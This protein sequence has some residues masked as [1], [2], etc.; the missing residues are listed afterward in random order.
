MCGRKKCK[1][2][3]QST[4]RIKSVKLFNPFKFYFG[5]R[6]EGKLAGGDLSPRIRWL[7][8]G[9]SNHNSRDLLIRTWIALLFFIRVRSANWLRHFILFYIIIIGIKN[10]RNRVFPTVESNN[11]YLLLYF[12]LYISN[13]L[14]IP[15]SIGLFNDYYWCCYCF[16]WWR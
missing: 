11:L 14:I 10:T 7:W 13:D 3:F 2:H 5:V 6:D 1:I 16:N 15:E 8:R 4:L 12:S 9:S